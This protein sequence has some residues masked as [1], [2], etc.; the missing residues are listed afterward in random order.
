MVI[1]NIL[2]NNYKFIIYNTKLKEVD[3]S[4]IDRG[5]TQTSSATNIS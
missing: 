3:S 2:E 4:A 5:Y 1:I